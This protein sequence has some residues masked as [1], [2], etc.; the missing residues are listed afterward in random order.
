M[1]ARQFDQSHQ[2]MT[3]VTSIKKRLPSQVLARQEI[4]TATKTDESQKNNELQ[5]HWSCMRP[6]SLLP[7]FTIFYMCILHAGP[8]IPLLK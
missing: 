2:P 6:C 5:V 1:R 3:N 7:L 8:Q 4:F